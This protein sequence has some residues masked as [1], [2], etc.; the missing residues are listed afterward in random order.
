VNFELSTADYRQVLF[1]VDNA[2]FQRVSVIQVAN[3]LTDSYTNV[4]TRRISCCDTF[5]NY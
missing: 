5:V 2:N 3:I 1:N 4:I